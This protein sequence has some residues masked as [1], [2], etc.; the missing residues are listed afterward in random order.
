MRTTFED[1]T[2]TR[3]LAWIDQLHYFLPLSS[4]PVHHPAARSPA[5]PS[6]TL[7]P[8]SPP[9]CPHSTSPGSPQDTPPSCWCSSRG[10]SSNIRL[11][12]GRSY[13]STHGSSW[14]DARRE[15]G[16]VR[17]CQRASP[18]PAQKSVW[19]DWVNVRFK[20]AHS[21]QK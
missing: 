20:S 2:S 19:A 5:T 6:G 21:L 12:R 18:K 10:S 1:L 11:E 9:L 17:R 7:R 8:D 3:Y 4:Q 16:T 14:E 13:I 15:R